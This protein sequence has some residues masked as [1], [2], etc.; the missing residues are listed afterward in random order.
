MT[1]NITI[2]KLLI[3]IICICILYL[4]VFKRLLRERY[5]DAPLRVYFNS[6]W[7]NFTPKIKQYFFD[8]LSHIYNRPVIE[9][10]FDESELLMESV[11]GGTRMHDKSWKHT[12]MFSGEPHIRD[13]YKDYTCVISGEADTFSPNNVAVPFYSTLLY[14]SVHR[15]KTAP[16]SPPPMPQKDVVVIISNAGGSVRNAFIEELDKHFQVTYAGRYKNNIGG[17]LEAG[18]GTEEFAKYISQF[19]YV[20]SMENSEKDSYITEKI[21]HGIHSHTIPVYWG[22]P[23]VTNYINP[24]RFIH[25]KSIDDILPTIEKMKSI[26]SSETEWQSMVMEPWE[27]PNGEPQPTPEN[28]AKKIKHKLPQLA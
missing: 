14:E 16:T 1:I 19:K 27:A 17:P 3:F 11:F 5:E 24:K 20:I 13:N 15:F 22:A 21:F 25:M 2:I 18:Y 12:Y 7:A 4:F 9:G 6:F 28:I 26:A 23:N 10:G 8:I